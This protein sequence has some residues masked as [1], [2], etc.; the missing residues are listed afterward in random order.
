MVKIVEVVENKIKFFFQN[1]LSGPF[2]E[3]RA[4]KGKQN[5]FSTWPKFGLHLILNIIKNLGRLV[6][7]S[8][9]QLFL[10]VLK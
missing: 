7:M 8:C 2:L 6:Y 10:K 4:G 1:F 5:I 3:G 9:L